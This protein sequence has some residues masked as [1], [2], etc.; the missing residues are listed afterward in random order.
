M[1]LVRPLYMK[2]IQLTVKKISRH[3]QISQAQIARMLDV[4]QKTFNSWLTGKVRCRHD[5]ILCL[6][7]RQLSNQIKKEWS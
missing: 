4:N 6:A 2:E 7:I 1:K 5:K 3:F